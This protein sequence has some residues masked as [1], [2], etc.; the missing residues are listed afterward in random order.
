V[1]A[2]HVVPV[3][4]DPSQTEG[5]SLCFTHHQAEERKL[6]RAAKRTRVS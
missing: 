3:G 4:D 6:R 2:H 1:Q 5:V